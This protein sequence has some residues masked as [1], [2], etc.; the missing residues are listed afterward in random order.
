MAR[1]ASV[2]VGGTVYGRIYDGGPGTNRLIVRDPQ[3]DSQITLSGGLA[4]GN[5][6]D[7]LLLS[8]GDSG[9]IDTVI[10]TAGTVH[11]GRSICFGRT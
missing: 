8:D 1:T 10:Y 7:T 6:G 9:T 4:L 3:A 11:P 2:T 5:K